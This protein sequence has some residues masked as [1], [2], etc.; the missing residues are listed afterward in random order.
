M[1]TKYGMSVGNILHPTDFSHGS[2]VAFAHALR[3]AV[4]AKGE[5]EIL[6]VDRYQTRA[7]WDSYPSVRDTLRKWRVLPAGAKR[8][9]VAKL[10]VRISKSAC[11]GSEPAVGVREHLEHRGA[12]LVVMATHR[13]EG[14]DRWLHSNL[15]ESI[16]NTTD[17]SSLFVPYGVDGFVDVETGVVSLNRILIPIDASPNPQPVLDVAAELVDAIAPGNVEIRLLHVGDPAGMPSPILPASEKCRW[18]WETAVGDVVDRICEDAH[19]NDVDLI[20]M[21]TN[22]HDGFLDALRGSTTERVLHQAKC[23][24]LSVPDSND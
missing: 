1:R 3:L 10:G 2:D 19:Q 17:G 23:P 14:L 16:S 4:D 13:R 7:D 8:T 11:K 9:D 6:H 21:A 15:A 18:N 20:A 5:L 24:V 12:D 22:G